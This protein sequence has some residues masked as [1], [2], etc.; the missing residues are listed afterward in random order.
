[1]HGWSIGGPGGRGKFSDAVQQCVRKP[2]EDAGEVIAPSSLLLRYLLRTLNGVRFSG[3]SSAMNVAQL[4]PELFLAPN[5]E[6]VIAFLPEVR[7][8]ADPPAGYALLQRL[9][10]NGERSTAWLTQ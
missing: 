7:R 10:G 9:D 4:F 5:M 2:G 8:V 3:A 6:V 1:M